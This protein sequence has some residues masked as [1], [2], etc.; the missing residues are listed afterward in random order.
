LCPEIADITLPPGWRAGSNQSVGRSHSKEWHMPTETR[1]PEAAS[2]RRRSI[3]SVP[4]GRIAKWLVLAFWMVVAG[5]LMPLAQKLTDVQTNDTSAWLP[6]SAEAT[7]ALDRAKAAFPDTNTIPAVVVYVRDGGLTAAD[8]GKVSADRG[9]LAQYGMGGKISPV[10]PSADGS[11]VLVTIPIDGSGGWQGLPDTVKKIRDT[12]AANAPPGLQTALAGP[13]AA[14]ADSADAFSG[15][16]TTLLFATIAVV[17]VI[18]LITYRSP[19]LWLIPLISVGIASQLASAVVYLL[20]KHAGLT[21][22][23]QS[24]GILTVLVFGAGTDYGLLLVARYREE[25]RRHQNRHEAMAIALRRSFSAIFASGTTV[26]LGMLCLLAAEMNSTRGLGPVA[27]I[28]IAVALLVMTTLLPALLVIFG[29]WLFWPFVPRYNPDVVG[30]DAAEDHGIWARISGFVGRHGRPLWIG[31]TLA[32]IALAFGSLTL[33]IGLTQADSFTKPVS[34]VSAQEL[35]DKHFPS[36]SSGPAQIYT[37]AQAASEVAAAAARVDGVAQVGQPRPSPDG[38]WVEIDAVLKD[39]P[40][41]SAAQKTVEALRDAVHGV[42]GSQALVGG[43]TAIQLDINHAVSHDNWL[44]MPLILAV[45]LIVLITLLRALVAPLLLMVSVVVSFLGAFGAAALIFAATGH[46][47]IDRGLP[48]FSYLF[49]VALGVD[50]TIFLMSRAREETARI[51]HRAGMLRALTVTGGVITSAGVV[52]A[53]TFSVL[54]ILPLTFMLQIGTI[55]AV[56]VLLDT[57][58][59]RTLVVPALGLDVGRRVW[60]PSRLSKESTAG[61]RAPDRELS[62][63]R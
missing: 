1:Q 49:L 15:L 58:V 54:A 25:L 55:V 4:S 20:A 56:G 28:G 26:I 52:L 21:V 8:Q 3:V 37:T 51:G 22:N 5:A 40:D 31:A 27:A 46:S 48:L 63:V 24:A 59:V 7:K 12:I 14:G 42:P 39:A 41:S 61:D 16:D 47:H 23:G 6:R 38:R 53:A 57:L 11:A 35:L 10:I 2:Q 50:Y 45:V 18:L 32:L 36:G 62:P 30:H 17:A 13:A 29:R 44:V 43:Q 33:K 9:V 34:S 19:S 60:W